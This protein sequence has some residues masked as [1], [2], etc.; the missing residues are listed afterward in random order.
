MG[1]DSDRLLAMGGG[2]RSQFAQCAKKAGRGSGIIQSFE[3]NGGGELRG[4]GA[5]ADLKDV[6]L[7]NRHQRVQFGRR[8]FLPMSASRQDDG[9]GFIDVPLP[10]LLSMRHDPPAVSAPTMPD[11]IESKAGRTAEIG[12]ERQSFFLLVHAAQDPIHG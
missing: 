2:A 10:L 8:I 1:D 7:A 3:R 6:L 11:D 5:E 9:T 12:F 4:L